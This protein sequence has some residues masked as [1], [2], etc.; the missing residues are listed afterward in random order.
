MAKRIKKPPVRPEVRK[1]WLN[2]HEQDGD[3]PPQIAATDGFDV[4]TVR[5]QIERAR[6]EREV[7]EARSIVLRNAME[8]HYADIC[9]FA[10]KLKVAV[11][12]EESI[13]LLVDDPLWLAL[14]QHLPRSPL[15]NPLNRRDTLLERLDVTRSSLKTRL[16]AEVGLDARLKPVLSS[17]GSGVVPGV[18]EYLAFQAGERSQGRKGLD[19]IDAY[20]RVKPA[21]DDLVSIEC[22]AFQ[23]GKVM[24]QQAATVKDVLIDWKSK[25]LSWEESHEMGRILAELQ[26]VRLKLRDELNTI[27]LRRI[28][29]G[30]CKYCPI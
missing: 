28:V 21:E 27:T 16:K 1:R 23:M 25:V 17:G 4:R 22:G 15:W 9:N 24:K 6:Q 8:R 3:S 7:R 14:K 12:G 2:R 26:R 29:P 19:D 20:F 30:R 5:K 13:S 18:V 11:A 10:E